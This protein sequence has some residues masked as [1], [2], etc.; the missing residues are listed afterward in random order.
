[1]KTLQKILATS[2]ILG[3]LALGT[4]YTLANTTP[5][6][7]ESKKPVYEMVVK[8]T[9]TTTETTISEYIDKSMVYFGIFACTLC[10]GSLFY[11]RLPVDNNG[12]QPKVNLLE[13][14]Y[15]YC[16]PTPLLLEIKN[17]SKNE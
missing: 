17:S 7:N 12:T 5:D 8:N 16:D 1:M 4:D 10:I 3:G 11:H 15:F 9:E 6:Y 13:K 14:P 2:I